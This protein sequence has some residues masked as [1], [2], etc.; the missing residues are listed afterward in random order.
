MSD[1]QRP[2]TTGDLADAER[3]AAAFWREQAEAHLA[4]LRSLRTRPVV[5]V[6][7][8]ADRALAPLRG[9]TGRTIAAVGSLRRRA[10]VTAR[11][12]ASRGDRPRRRRALRAAVAGL[13]AA[14]PHR[15][16]TVLSIDEACSDSGI[17]AVLDLDRRIAAAPTEFVC[18]HRSNIEAL[19]R[20]W[21]ERLR[22]A[23]AD[24][25]VAASAHIVHPDRKLP[26]ATPHDMLT[27]ERGLAVEDRLGTPLLIALGA[28]DEVRDGL[29]LDEVPAASASAVL[30]R[31]D[32]VTSVGGLSGSVPD[33][34]AAIVEL[35]IRL[36]AAGGRVLCVG[37]ALVAD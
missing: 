6:A 13:P 3:A 37:E 1:V 4:D 21:V 19:D 20:R 29:H 14:D 18:I 31:R 24:G 28:G 35:C 17:G 2:S 7:L 33:V 27:R 32:A 8:R 22:A 34:D 15:D 10:S 5:R 25:V 36:R 23:M 16:V 30:L 26:H 11:A 9:P 12:L